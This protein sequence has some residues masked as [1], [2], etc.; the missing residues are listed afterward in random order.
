MAMNYGH[1]DF[2]NGDW[3]LPGSF[4]SFE[5]EQEQE[6]GRYPKLVG[7]KRAHETSRNV[8]LATDSRIA[9]VRAFLGSPMQARLATQSVRSQN[10]PQM[11]A[12]STSPARIDRL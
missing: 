8:N 6:W 12:G 7:P 3:D 1:R 10:P 9:H 4:Q 5:G 2:K 11:A